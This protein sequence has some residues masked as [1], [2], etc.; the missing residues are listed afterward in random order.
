MRQ[1]WPYGLEEKDNEACNWD[2]VHDN[3]L[4][5]YSYLFFV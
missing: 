2:T 1:T 5:Y 3:L 4:D